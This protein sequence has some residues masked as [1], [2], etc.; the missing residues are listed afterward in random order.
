MFRQTCQKNQSLAEHLLFLSDRLMF[1]K[2]CFYYKFTIISA[3]V[4]GL[5]TFALSIKQSAGIRNKNIHELN[6]TPKN[7]YF[8]SK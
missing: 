1:V 6:I 4:C 5:T 3:I 7:N 8:C 2:P